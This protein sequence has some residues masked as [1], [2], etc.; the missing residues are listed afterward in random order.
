[1]PAALLGVLK[2]GA[3]YVP[4]DPVS[5]PDRLRFMLRDVECRALVAG[6]GLLELARSI[7]GHLPLIEPAKLPD[8]GEPLNV[9]LSP[10]RAAYAIF[11]SGSTGQPKAVV[12]EHR[13]AVNLC[14]WHQDFYRVGTASRA[15]LFASPCFDASLWEMLP[16]LTAG[17]CLYPVEP[18]ARENVEE[19]ISFQLRHGIT[20]AFV[21]PALCE[22]VCRRQAGRLSGKMR[23]LTGGDVL[24]FF[25]DGSLQVVNNYGPTEYAV[26]A[27]AEYLDA[28][29]HAQDIPI[30]R[31]IAGTEVLLLDAQ[32]RLVPFGGIGEIC[33]SGAGLARGYLNRPE[34]NAEKFVAH[35][36]R[37]GCRMYRTGDLGRWRNDRSLE[38]LGRRDAQVKIRGFRIEPAE[39][40]A[41]LREHAD[42][43]GAA[44]LPHRNAAGET[45][46]AAYVVVPAAVGLESLRVHLAALLPAYMIPTHFIRM[47][48]LP[49]TAAGKT[50][51]AALPPPEPL[52][53]VAVSEPRTAVETALANIWE[54]V[55][56]RPVRG[57]NENFF[58]LGGHS[59]A[60]MRVAGLIRDRLQVEP[61]LRALFDHPTVASLAVV[62]EQLRNAASPASKEPA[63]VKRDR[64]AYL[65]GDAEKNRR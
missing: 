3:V 38:F 20:H 46:L 27:T 54:T 12:V 45:E 56:A 4:L 33:L 60:A 65:D 15:T 63:L 53:V 55:L 25:G 22:E 49:V 42:V 2:A 52:A 40:E 9:V 8:V 57:A 30:G 61:S 43:V 37:S 48:R 36:F 14:L 39:I 19:L 5:P 51:R 17:A 58:D 7:A 13:S 35:P 28:A 11:T 64:K 50:D 41:R 18:A 44:V 34:L 1:L 31:P 47:E 10:E 59:V 21:P 6:P 29:R 24:R 26:V 16:Y 23:L 62:V 32:L